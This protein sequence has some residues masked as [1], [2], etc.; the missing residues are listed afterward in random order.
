MHR[1][2][3]VFI[4]F[5]CFCFSISAQVDSSIVLEEIIVNADYR[6]SKAS[7]IFSSVTVL[8]ANLIRKKNAQHL[9]DMLFNAPN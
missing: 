7:D 4:T 2:F 5:T 3:V 9:E 6:Q 8:D 1:I